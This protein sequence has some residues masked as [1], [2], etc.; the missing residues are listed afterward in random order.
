ML[1]KTIQE[2]LKPKTC[3]EIKVMRQAKGVIY[4]GQTYS[5]SL[6]VVI[7][8]ERDDFKFG[9]VEGVV[10]FIEMP[11]IYYKQLLIV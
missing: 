5:N 8:Y 10:S 4:E 7:G 9:K 2:K 6:A 3:S 11:Y 1:K